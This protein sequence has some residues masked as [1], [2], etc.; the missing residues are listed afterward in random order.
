MQNL[1]KASPSSQDTKALVVFSQ[2]QGLGPAPAESCLGSSRAESIE[3]SQKGSVRRRSLSRGR[4]YDFN[5]KAAAL[6]D[7]VQD[8]AQALAQA[9]FLLLFTCH[10][11]TSCEFF[12]T[13][14][15]RGTCEFDSSQCS[16]LRGLEPEAQGEE[17]VKVSREGR[18][19]GSGRWWQT[20]RKTG[21]WISGRMEGWQ[22]GRKH[23]R[24]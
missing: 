9:G 16:S 7:I 21:K 22:D 6:N 18:G 15:S 20:S 3:S 10:V 12:G 23:Y 13:I 19:Q 11:V 24:G 14:V 5:M 2:G 4:V 17:E 8:L 1:Y